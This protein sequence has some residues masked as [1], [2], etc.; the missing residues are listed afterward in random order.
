M[1]KNSLEGLTES[2]FI[3]MVMVYYREKIRIKISQGK[4]CMEQSL[5]K[6]L[7]VELLLTPSYGVMDNITFLTMMHDSTHRAFPTRE[8]YSNLNT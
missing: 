6:V 7:N 4:K 1:F 3:L 2:G 5:G 8:A